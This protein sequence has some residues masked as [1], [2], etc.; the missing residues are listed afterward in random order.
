MT[1]EQNEPIMAGSDDA[2]HSE[3]IEGILAQVAADAPGSSREEVAALLKQRFDNAAIDLD[4]AEIA[5]LAARVT[6][7]G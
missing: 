4:D 7:G 6:S 1:D 2:G 3:K 5:E